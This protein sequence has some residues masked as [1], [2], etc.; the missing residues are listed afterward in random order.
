MHGKG[1]DHF[2]GNILQY[3]HRMVADAKAQEFKVT[4]DNI[5]ALRNLLVHYFKDQEDVKVM[6]GGNVLEMEFHLHHA[7]VAYQFIFGFMGMQLQ[8][9]VLPSIDIIVD[10][11]KLSP[12]QIVMPHD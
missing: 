8:G 2:Y 4:G 11:P 9:L 1:D 12:A 3:F 6:L 10:S 7:K 5:W